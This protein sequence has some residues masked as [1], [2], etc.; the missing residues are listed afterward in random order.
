MPY[1][2]LCKWRRTS[3][4]VKGR[5][6][7]RHIF[8]AGGGRSGQATGKGSGIGGQ[9]EAL[10]GAFRAA[11]CWTM[12]CRQALLF[13]RLSI[14]SHPPSLLASSNLLTVPELLPLETVAGSLGI[15]STWLTEQFRSRVSLQMW[16]SALQK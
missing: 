2:K 9:P 15:P 3:S 13:C 11:C 7:Q 1:I 16:P 14:V 4:L 12:S 5:E 8:Y 10:V 6:S